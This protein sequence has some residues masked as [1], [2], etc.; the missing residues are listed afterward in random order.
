MIDENTTEDVGDEDK[1]KNIV[2]IAYQ[3]DDEGDMVLPGKETNG[4]QKV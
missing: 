2:K 3:V 4:E 1:G